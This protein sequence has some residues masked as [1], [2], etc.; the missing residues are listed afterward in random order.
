MDGSH[1]LSDVART[2]R[3]VDSVIEVRVATTSGCRACG[4]ESQHAHH[5]HG[6]RNSDDTIPLCEP[7]HKA[8]HRISEDLRRTG[9]DVGIRRSLFAVIHA[10]AMI[11]ATERDAE[12]LR[13]SP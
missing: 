13:R 10:Q 7:C 6:R 9:D 3:C 8:V 1:D 12:K 4:A 2:A 5:L 11:D